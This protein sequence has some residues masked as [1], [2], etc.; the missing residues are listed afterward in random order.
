MA[1]I[2]PNK[3]GYIRLSIGRD[4]HMTERNVEQIAESIAAVATPFSLI[5]EFQRVRLENI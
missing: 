3:L 2:D 5:P 4:S 1:R